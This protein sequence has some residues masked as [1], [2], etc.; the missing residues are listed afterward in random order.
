VNTSGDH[1]QTA[2]GQRHARSE[3]FI[4]TLGFVLAVSALWFF[5][6][7]AEEMLEGSTAQFDSQVRSLVHAHSIGE[8]TAVMKFLTLFGSSP[9]MAPL[10]L[11]ALTLCYIRREFHA[12]KMLAATFAGAL[13]LELLLKSIF[14][15]RAACT[16]FRYFETCL[17]QLSQRSR[18]V[19]ILLFCRAPRRDFS[20]IGAPQSQNCSLAHI[21]R[22][23][24]WDWIFAHLSGR[25][26][27]V[28]RLGWLCSRSRLG[29]H[30]EL[31]G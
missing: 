15:S 21:G 20:T 16:L 10:A 27:P 19:L 13:V 23:D 25:P 30:A 29:R 31:R 8:V 6:W 9:V 7:I 14:S 24:L 28:R 18:A 3:R 22:T 5:A 17:L 12:L 2:A 11:L 1:Q 26:L 4:L